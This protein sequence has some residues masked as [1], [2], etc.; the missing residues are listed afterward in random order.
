T[1]PDYS[2]G[3]ASRD[4]RLLE[5]LL[6]TNGYQPIYVNLTRKDLD[7]PVVKAIIP[8]LEMF[9]EFD[10]FSNPSLRQFAHY[11]KALK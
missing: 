11:L 8:G 5:R 4:L 2:S 9:A 6:I 1:L 7:I 3:N 10:E